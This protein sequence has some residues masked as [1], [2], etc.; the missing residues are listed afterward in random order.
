MIANVNAVHY[1]E[2][3]DRQMQ[4]TREIY[5]ESEDAERTAHNW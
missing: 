5:V 3:E 2:A 1:K 4:I